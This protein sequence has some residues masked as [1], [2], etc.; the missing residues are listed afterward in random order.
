[1]FSC[2]KYRKDFISS[3]ITENQINCPIRSI[4]VSDFVILK[5]YTVL[6]L[7]ESKSDRSEHTQL[8]LWR[9]NF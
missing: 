7:E 1:M 8:V 5:L 9:I 3:Q 2:K 4:S 6:V